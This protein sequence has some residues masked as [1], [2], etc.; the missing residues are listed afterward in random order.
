[1]KRL[2]TNVFIKRAIE[3]HGNKYDYSITEYKNSRIKIKYICPEHGIIEQL[4]VS[5]Y[6]GRGCHLCSQQNNANKKSFDTNEFIK[7]AKLIHGN[8]YDYSKTEYINS[9]EKVCVVCLKHGEFWQKANN[10]IYQK[11]GC[12]KCRESKS[13]TKIRVFLKR[14]KIDYEKEKVFEDC[15]SNGRNLFFDFYLPQF[16]MCVEYDGKQ[17]Y[18]P[19]YLWGENAFNITKRTDKIKNL[20]CKDKGIKLIRIPYTSE[21]KLES[22]LQE[23][24][25]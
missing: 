9:Q 22:I 5:H 12:P 3:I 16:N 25:L 10:H 19:F 7:R 20:Y 8:K 2:T 21:N 24:L 13:E 15:K 11:S 6:Q 14:N 18:E 4:P 1:M 23:N 17:H